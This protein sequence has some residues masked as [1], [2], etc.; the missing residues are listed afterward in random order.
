M[1]R[2]T[3]EI[4]SRDTMPAVA[5]YTA[6]GHERFQ[7]SKVVMLGILTGYG[8]D[9]ISEPEIDRWRCVP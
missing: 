2:A 1:V 6:L 3:R 4:A 7:G 9:V 5:R 8:A